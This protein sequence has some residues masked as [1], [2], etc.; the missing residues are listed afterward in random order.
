MEQ[1]QLGVNTSCNVD[2]NNFFQD[3]CTTELILPYMKEENMY[4]LGFSIRFSIYPSVTFLWMQ[5]LENWFDFGGWGF[6]GECDS[7]LVSGKFLNNL[8]YNSRKCLKI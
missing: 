2:C 6:K 1:P 8:Q 4:V 7:D 5:Y 3:R